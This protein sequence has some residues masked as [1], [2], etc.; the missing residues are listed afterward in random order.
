M[1]IQ[2]R[3]Q[4]LEVEVALLQ[5]RHMNMEKSVGKILEEVKIISYSIKKIEEM[6]IAREARE[7]VRGTIWKW[8]GRNYRFILSV[9]L[10]AIAPSIFEIGAK[11]AHL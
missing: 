1:E 11:F 4:K 9:A 7:G 3:I 8:I 6:N 5:E 2:N 10:I